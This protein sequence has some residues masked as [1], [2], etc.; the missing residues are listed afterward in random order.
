MEATYGKK[1][2]KEFDHCDSSV[3]FAALFVVFALIGIYDSAGSA[4]AETYPTYTAPTAKD[5]LIYTGS[6][7]TLVNR[8][9]CMIYFVALLLHSVCYD[10]SVSFFYKK[11]INFFAE[12]G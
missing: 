12:R 6:A 2:E 8:I 9:Y 5:D 10:N 7:Q 3:M 4:N 11:S 1:S